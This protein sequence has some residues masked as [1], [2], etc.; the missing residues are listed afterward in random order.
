MPP[1]LTE[2]KTD[3]VPPVHYIV[4]TKHGR[5]IY[6]DELPSEISSWRR[7]RDYLKESGD[8]IVRCRIHSPHKQLVCE[9]ESPRFLHLIWRAKKA[10]NDVDNPELNGIH[11]EYAIYNGGQFDIFTWWPVDNWVHQGFHKSYLDTELPPNATELEQ[12]QAISINSIGLIV[13]SAT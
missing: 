11:K 10:F 12:K 13:N 1:I 7:L 4:S 5:T 6:E 3:N 9:P 8:I 2:S